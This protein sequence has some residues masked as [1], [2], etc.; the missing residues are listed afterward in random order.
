MIKVENGIIQ[1]KEIEGIKVIQSLIPKSNK[2]SRP[3]YSMKAE[4]ITIHNVGNPGTTA[5]QNSKFVDNT[6]KYLSWHLTIGNNVI[7]QELPFIE[8]SWNAGDG[9]NGVGNRKSIAIEICDNQESIDTAIKF[10]P[11]LLKITGLTIDKIVPH[12]HWSGKE[13]PWLI[14]PMWDQ[15]IKEIENGTKK[16]T[17]KLHPIM[18]KGQADI[19]QMTTLA[20]N[21][22][23]EFKIN[24][25]LDELAQ[26]FI[27]ES[28]IEGVNHDVAWCQS[29]HET[30]YFQYKGQALP[31]WN[32][33]SGLGVTGQI[34]SDGIPLGNKFKTPREGIRAQIQ[35]LKAYASKESL[36]GKLIDERFD[37]VFRGSAPY[38]E[39]L[40][41]K[42]NPT[43]IGWAY[44]G[45]GYGDRI[46]DYMNLLYNIKGKKE[47]FK[48]VY[49]TK[50]AGTY[51][52]KFRENQE[53]YVK[54]Y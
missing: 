25:G 35:H 23:K 11:Y 3:Q 5:E 1:N 14:L 12:K 36:N 45:Q 32:N 41:A 20:F 48:L 43:G 21:K 27:E 42:D 52:I 7:Y 29:I 19:Y 26:M 9:S 53:L 22:Y 50:K 37:L 18:S 6:D 16:D 15:F 46:V 38:V 17:S 13:C 4:W 39:Y 34:G 40:G 10:I 49:H 33:Y 47:E 30:G 28:A 8:S 54:T 2:T 31:E 51:K 24:C 44:P